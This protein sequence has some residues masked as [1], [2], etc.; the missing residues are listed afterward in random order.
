MFFF[1]VSRFFPS[2]N[3]KSR[4]MYCLEQCSRSCTL[5]GT[6]DVHY[7]LLLCRFG[8]KLIIMNKNFG[9]LLSC[10]LIYLSCQGVT[11]QCCT[12]EN[13]RS[14]P[15]GKR[16]TSKIDQQLNRK[17]ESKWQ[18]KLNVNRWP[19]YS[20]LASICRRLNTWWPANSGSSHQWF[21]HF[22]SPLGGRKFDIISCFFFSFIEQ[23]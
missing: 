12:N 7:Q 3:F 5:A 20:S 22:L 1:Q 18:Y 17:T 6:T 15:A 21:W 23:N 2:Y 13:S 9:G 16:N 4:Q 14:H 10:F 8:L 11:S 19:T